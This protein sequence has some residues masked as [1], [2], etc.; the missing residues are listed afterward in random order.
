MEREPRAKV[1]GH[2]TKWNEVATME[3]EKASR[4]C[5]FVQ[6]KPQGAGGRHPKDKATSLFQC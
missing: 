1:R 4:C 3:G 5:R 2:V 6:R